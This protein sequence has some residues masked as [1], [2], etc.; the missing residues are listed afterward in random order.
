MGDVAP[1][2]PHTAAVVAALEAA[3]VL[4]GRATAPEGGGWQGEPGHSPYVPYAVI[5]PSPGVP[6]GNVAEPVAYLDYTA[7]INC[8]GADADQAET[9]ADQVRAPLIGKRLT[10]PGR[11]CYPVQQPPGSPPTARIDTPPPPEFRAVVEI[12]FRSQAV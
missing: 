9:C 3:G 4:V 7:Q 10:V 8:W 2:A 1:S 12:A 11:S 6:D 5:Y